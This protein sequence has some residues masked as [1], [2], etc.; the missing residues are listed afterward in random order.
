MMRRYPLLVSFSLPFLLLPILFTSIDGVFLLLCQLMHKDMNNILL[1]P[2]LV[3]SIDGELLLLCQ[4]MHKDMNKILLKPEKGELHV[5]IQ[6][7]QNDVKDVNATL[8]MSEESKL[9][10]SVHVGDSKSREGKLKPA[11]DAMTAT[12]MLMFR[13]IHENMF[14]L[15]SLLVHKDM[16][17]LTLISILL[18]SSDDT[19]AVNG[20]FINSEAPSQSIH[21]SSS[22]S[23]FHHTNSVHP[24]SNAISGNEPDLTGKMYLSR[25]LEEV[26]SDRLHHNPTV[27]LFGNQI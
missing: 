5:P 11:N 9:Y 14:Q 24:S 2:I 27:S 15:M 3:T 20:F 7:M 21:S 18:T 25:F 23:D 16:S 17:T 8:L 19:W 6:R 10:C 22:S 12:L 26:D 4:L 13:S 1:L